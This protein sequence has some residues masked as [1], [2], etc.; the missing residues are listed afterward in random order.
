MVVKYKKPNPKKKVKQQKNSAVCKMFSNPNSKNKT[1][2]TAFKL[3]A[4][5]IYQHTLY[6]RLN[7]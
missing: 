2:L 1:H 4:A 5:D 3:L 6:A 7:V